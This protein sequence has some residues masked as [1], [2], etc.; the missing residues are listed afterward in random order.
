MSRCRRKLLVKSSERSTKK[1]HSSDDETGVD[2]VQHIRMLPSIRR[3]TAI[4][5]MAIWPRIVHMA[6]D[7][8]KPDCIW[9]NDLP[10]FTDVLF[11][12]DPQRPCSISL[13]TSKIY[14]EKKEARGDFQAPLM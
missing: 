1:C 14:R 6:L 12:R 2:A 7:D 8:A 13:E 5:P 11:G 3:A 4:K 9:L 10:G